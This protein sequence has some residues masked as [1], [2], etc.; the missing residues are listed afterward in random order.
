MAQSND[1]KKVPPRTPPQRLNALVRFA[2]ASVNV[3]IANV[4]YRPGRASNMII[5]ISRLDRSMSNAFNKECA[6][7]DPTLAN[8]GP[9]PATQRK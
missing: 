7:F 5:G 4:I 3:Q 2:N 8:G 9:N 6:F 1:E